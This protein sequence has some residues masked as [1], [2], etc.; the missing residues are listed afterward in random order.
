MTDTVKSQ[1]DI[2]EHIAGLLTDLFELERDEIKP[3]SNLYEDL[4]IDSIDAV[5]LVVEL[6]QWTGKKIEPEAFK[7]VRTVQDVVEAVE[8]L[9]KQ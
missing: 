8:P 9:L 1:A 7:S 5:D 2:F 3:E 6:K 4:D